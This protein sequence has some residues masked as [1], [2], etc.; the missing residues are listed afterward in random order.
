MKWIPLP[1]QNLSS[2]HEGSKQNTTALSADQT[3]SQGQE[4]GGEKELGRQ[5]RVCGNSLLCGPS[6]RSGPKPRAAT[7]SVSGQHPAIA[8]SGPGV[9]ENCPPRGDNIWKE[10]G[11]GKSPSASLGPTSLHLLWPPPTG[12]SPC[13]CPSPYKNSTGFHEQP[14]GASLPSAAAQAGETSP[15]TRRDHEE[16]SPSLHSGCLGGGSSVLRWETFLLPFFL[17]FPSASDFSLFLFFPLPPPLLPPFSN[18]IL[19]NHQFN[20][21]QSLWTLMGSIKA[22][23]HLKY[24]DFCRQLNKHVLSMVSHY[25][26]RNIAVSERRY[27]IPSP[28]VLIFRDVYLYSGNSL[29]KGIS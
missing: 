12:S 21:S 15:G 8:Q 26:S 17:F 25:T 23:L 20:I 16:P 27:Q 19:K 29:V 6:P 18:R 10:W 3:C 5:T 28:W 13:S 7:T 1:P 24:P 2:I 14:A 22:S 11:F 4:S 9:R